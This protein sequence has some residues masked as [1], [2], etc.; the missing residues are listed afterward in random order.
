MLPNPLLDFRAWSRTQPDLTAVLG[1]RTYWH[2]PDQVVFPA[3]R[4]YQTYYRIQPGQAP[5][6]DADLS[7]DIWAGSGEDF[8]TV[9]ETAA[10]LVEALHQL[11]SGTVIGNCKVLNADVINAVPTADPEAGLPRF[12]VDARITSVYTP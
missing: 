5:V 6:V 7:W 3:A 1:D 2:F 11:G 4:L 10:T 12:L 8:T 9:A